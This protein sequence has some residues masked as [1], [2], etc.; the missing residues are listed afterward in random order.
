MGCNYRKSEASK[1]GCTTT[2]TGFS[3]VTWVVWQRIGLMFRSMG[4]QGG[5]QEWGSQWFGGVVVE[6]GGIGNECN[7]QHWLGYQGEP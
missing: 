1:Q 5:A 7:P 4:L 3:T 6:G 2:T